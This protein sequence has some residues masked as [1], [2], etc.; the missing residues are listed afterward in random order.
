MKSKPWS[1]TDLES[2]LK[3]LKGNK[4]RDPHG[5]IND[6]F[7]LGI[8]G[9]DL[10]KSLLLMYNKIREKFEIPD[11]VQW[12]NITSLYKGKGNFY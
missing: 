10:K 12:A 7:K 3:A 11:F 1:I 6:L 5:L 9:N 2:V 4:S 8:I